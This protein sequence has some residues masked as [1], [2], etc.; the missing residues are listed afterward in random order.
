MFFHLAPGPVNGGQI[1]R[2]ALRQEEVHQAGK[3]PAG[4]AAI[5]N[6]RERRPGAEVKKQIG[7]S[8]GQNQRDCG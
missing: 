2:G 3:T 5:A 4:L 6:Q 8:E 7:P 1:R